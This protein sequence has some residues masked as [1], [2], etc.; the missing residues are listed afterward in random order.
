M[1][2]DRVEG[3]IPSVVVFVVLIVLI[4]LGKIKG[5]FHL[6]TRRIVS[7]TLWIESEPDL[8]FVADYRLRLHQKVLRCEFLM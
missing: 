2:V 5:S 8:T 1:R 7:M 6:K 4:L 3:H